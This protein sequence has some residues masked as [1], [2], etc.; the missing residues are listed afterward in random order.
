MKF[1]TGT[2]PPLFHKIISAASDI[3]KVLLQNFA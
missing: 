1:I 2:Y 3:F